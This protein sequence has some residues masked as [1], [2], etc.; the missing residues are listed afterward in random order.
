[1]TQETFAS[2][3]GI[4]RS[5]LSEIEAG[6]RRPSR[7]LLMLIEGRFQMSLGDK[8]ADVPVM[9]EGRVPYEA[10]PAKLRNLLD[11][12]VEVMQSDS[13]VEKEALK[14]NIDAFVQSVRMRKK[15]GVTDQPKVALKKAAIENGET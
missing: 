8:P 2:L 1:M 5:F 9:A 14:A 15:I 4:S 6:T 12:V 11:A 10:Y 3:L 7:S 13:A